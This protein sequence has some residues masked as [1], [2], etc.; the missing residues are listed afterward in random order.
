MQQKTLKATKEQ[1]KGAIQRIKERI[2]NNIF[3][4]NLLKDIQKTGHADIYHDGKYKNTV[5]QIER[6]LDTKHAIKTNAQSTPFDIDEML[7]QV[8]L[9]SSEKI[10]KWLYKD[11]KRQPRIE[12]HT[13]QP[14]QS[15][16]KGIIKT[17]NMIQERIAYQG[18]AI[19]EKADNDYGFTLITAYP[20]IKFTSAQ[21]INRDI[22]PELHKTNAY[23][24]ASK[25]QKQIW[26]QMVL[27]GLKKPGESDVK[28]KTTHPYKRNMP[29]NAEELLAAETKTKNDYH[30]EK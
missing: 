4:T 15:L 19:L 29:H 21:P 18:T 26:D 30:F 11:D 7:E 23:K 5:E 8:I 17:N 20:N 1:Q 12:C 25:E 6:I 27:N 2:E 3:S 24:N 22:R 10:A 28:K 13:E 9:D 16:G 14:M